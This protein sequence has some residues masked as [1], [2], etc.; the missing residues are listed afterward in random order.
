MLKNG[1]IIRHISDQAP[2]DGSPMM[3]MCHK[4]KGLTLVKFKGLKKIPLQ[5]F[6]PHDAAIHKVGCGRFNAWT[7]KRHGEWNVDVW[8]EGGFDS[9]GMENQGDAILLERWIKKYAE[10][11]KHAELR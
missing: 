10:R 1:F 6:E 8:H 3:L 7:G 4:E 11:K 2:R 9:F 5:E